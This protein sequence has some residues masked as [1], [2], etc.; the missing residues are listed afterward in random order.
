MSNLLEKQGGLAKLPFLRML[1]RRSVTLLVIFAV[2]FGTILI[3]SKRLGEICQD[4]SCT[5]LAGLK[6]G[7]ASHLKDSH[8]DDIRD[9]IVPFRP[10]DAA[11]D[12]FPDTSRVLLVMKTGASESYNRI[13]TQLMTNLKCLP[14]FLIFGDKEQEIAGYRIHDSLDTIL[15]RAKE[16]NSDFDLYNRQ[17]LCPIDVDKCNKHSDSASEGWALDKYKNIHIAEK[18]YKLRPGYD[19][20]LF[21][22]ADTYVLWST[23][24]Q[25]LKLLDPSVKKYIGSA[26]MISDFAFAHGGSGYLV[27]QAAMGGLFDGKENVA[28]EWDTLIHNECCGDYM[29]G[30]ALHNKTGAMVQNVVSPN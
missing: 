16:G 30:R 26:T 27:S 8:D 10:H 21:V 5:D 17:Q 15:P 14:E 25:W 11:C 19:W 24:V 3:A 7:I 2:F 18:T 1:S 4:G 23:L 29:F 22:D 12:G 20:Y 6:H 28:N 13:P 9:R